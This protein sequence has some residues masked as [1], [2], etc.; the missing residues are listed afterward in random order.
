MTKLQHTRSAAPGFW[1][2]K[3]TDITSEITRRCWFLDSLLAES[4]SCHDIRLFGGQPWDWTVPFSKAAKRCRLPINVIALADVNFACTF[5]MAELVSVGSSL[6]ICYFLSCSSVSLMD[7]WLS[8]YFTRA[9]FGFTI[10]HSVI[11]E[12]SNHRQSHWK[13]ATRLI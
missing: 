3:P 7:Q 11:S 12:R 8:S 5:G 1:C 6:S 13:N 4:V 10:R 9:G 2:F